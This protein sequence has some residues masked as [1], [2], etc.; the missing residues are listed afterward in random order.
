MR[1]TGRALCTPLGPTFFRPNNNA[2]RGQISKIVSNSAGFS[3]P[4]AGQILRYCPRLYIYD[5]IQRLV[6]R[7]VISGYTCGGQGE[8][9]NPPFG[10]PYF[11][12]NNNATRG[13]TTKIVANTFL[14]GCDTPYRGD[15]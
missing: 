6:S 8:P 2:T 5:F 12:P 13:Q 11:R 15:K 14:P 9:C 4:P 10:R 1:R 3:D 7:G